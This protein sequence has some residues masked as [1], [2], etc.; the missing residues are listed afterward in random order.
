MER[1][2]QNPLCE[3]EAAKIVPVSV[4]KPSDQK[5]ALCAACEEVYTWGVQHGGLTS[6]PKR[7]W[8]LQVS[9]AGSAVHAGVFRSRRKAVRNL[10][11]YLRG[12]EG[13]RGP[14]DLSTICDWLA[15]HNERLGVD[16]FPASVD[17]T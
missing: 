6:R 12:Q 3:N 11:T 16:I 4:D 13:Y 14:E 15:E 1:Y 5:R 8:V 17:L 2:C 10:V 7:V 9:D